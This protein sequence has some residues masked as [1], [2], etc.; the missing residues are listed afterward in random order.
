MG[1][2]DLKTYQVL[3]RQRLPPLPPGLRRRRPRSY[4]EW[5]ALR[6]WGKLPAWEDS[7]A[8]YLLRL[9]REGAGLTQQQLGAMLGCSQQAVAQAERPTSNPTTALLRRWTDATGARAIIDIDLLES[10]GSLA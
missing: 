10:R 3:R 6:R 8:G 7:P 9:A 1:E 2:A 4:A 5:S